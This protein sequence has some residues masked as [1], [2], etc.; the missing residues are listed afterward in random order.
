MF[1]YR[2]KDNYAIYNYVV[3]RKNLLHTRGLNYRCLKIKNIH[4]L[5]LAPVGCATYY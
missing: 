5:T 3:E 4:N 2:C 1:L